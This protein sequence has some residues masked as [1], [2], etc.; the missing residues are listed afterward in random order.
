[1][2]INGDDVIMGDA[3]IRAAKEITNATIVPMVTKAKMV[4]TVTVVT[5]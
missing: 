5:M 1:M 3:I 2:D 4:S